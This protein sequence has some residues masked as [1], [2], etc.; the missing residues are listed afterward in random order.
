MDE[1][2]FGKHGFHS[3]QALHSKENALNLKK[4]DA[5]TQTIDQTTINLTELG[6]TKLLGTGSITKALTITVA[7][8][9]KSA[10]EK[11]KA[12]GGKIITKENEEATIEK[13][14]E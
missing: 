10:A 3:P 2:Y 1:K 13:P 4:L 11:I 8:Y 14:T 5:L 12:A 9:S 6:Y 7:S